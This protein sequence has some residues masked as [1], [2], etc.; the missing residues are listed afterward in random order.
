MNKIIYQDNLITKFLIESRKYGN[1][2]ILVDTDDW[3][4]ISQYKWYITKWGYNF[5]AISTKRIIENKEIVMHRFILN[6][7]RG[8]I[9]DHKNRNSLDNRKEN[10]RIVTNQQNIW[11]QKLH[12]DN[13]SGYIG[14]HWNKRDKRWLA[15]IKYNNKMLYLGYFKDKIEAALAYNNKAKE[16]RGEFAYLNEI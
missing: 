1:I 15:Y 11:N 6:A 2:E 7:K 4:K 3:N 9:V 16:L 10:L 14:V 13:T 8:E 12:R 5:Y